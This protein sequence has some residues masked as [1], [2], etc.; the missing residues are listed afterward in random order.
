LHEDNKIGPLLKDHD[1]LFSQ[2]RV[3]TQWSFFYDLVPLIFMEQVNIFDERA[4]RPSAKSFILIG[5]TV[6]LF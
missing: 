3:F 2:N 4:V 1:D 5:V 6:F